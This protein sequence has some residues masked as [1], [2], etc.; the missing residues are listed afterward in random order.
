MVEFPISVTRCLRLPVYHTMRYFVPGWMFR[1]WLRGL[2]RTGLPVC[3][4]FH[5]A[6]L[7]GLNEDGVDQRMTRHPGMQRPL[8]EKTGILRDIL[9]T[10]AAERRVVTYRAALA[11]GLAG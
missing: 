7:L 11:E 6:D 10:I 5:A 8:A 3:Y 9:A 4:E 2:L 1:R